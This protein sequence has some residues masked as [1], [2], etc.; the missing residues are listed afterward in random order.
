MYACVWR[1]R[2]YKSA[3]AGRSSVCGGKGYECV[4]VSVPVCGCAN[5]QAEAYERAC[6]C[7]GV[8]CLCVLG[9]SRCYVHM[10]GQDLCM[11]VWDSGVD[12]QSVCADLSWYFSNKHTPKDSLLTK[13][14]TG[15]QQAPV[16][17][18]HWAT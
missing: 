16:G 14:E 2:V 1:L 15:W 11:Y 4:F 10:Y 12:W 8:G 17:K 9:G 5:R 13:R 7:V 18:I 3:W 6:M